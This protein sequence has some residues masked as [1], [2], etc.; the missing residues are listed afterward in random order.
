M[1]EIAAV[2]ESQLTDPI[3]ALR[4]KDL[5]KGAAQEGAPPDFPDAPG[6][7]YFL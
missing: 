7:V 3:K 5:L 4:Q 1:S 2:A 6:D